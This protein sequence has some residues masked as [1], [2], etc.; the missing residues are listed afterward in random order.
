M[1]K[2]LQFLGEKLL[3]KKYEIA[4]K[5]HEKRPIQ[6]DMQPMSSEV[7]N[8]VL[9]LRAGFIGMFGNLLIEQPDQ[10]TAEALF[11]K[12]GKETGEKAYLLGVSLDE[13]LK[14]TMYYRRY[15]WEVLEEEMK[16]HEM[17]L[18]TALTVNKLINPLLDHASYAFGLTYVRFHENTLAKAKTAFLEL[19]IPVVPI[20]KGIAILPLIGAIDTER[21]RLMMEEVL[22]KASKLQLTHLLFD[23]SGVEI[24]D[25]MVADQIFKIESALSLL[26]VKAI[27]I[28]IRPE[29]AQTMVTL[30][31]NIESLT[32]K[33]NLEQALKEL[34]HSIK[35]FS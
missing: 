27:F 9:E 3:E 32:V 4:Q 8:Q 10:A 6:K 11:S 24:V 21:A 13:S 31:V 2:E 14:R 19:S 12:W 1:D 25:T 20:T 18:E 29:V 28:G 22:Q 16:K 23:L 7:L 17:A 26:G 30:G 34:Q 33:S 5:V 35:L 15:I